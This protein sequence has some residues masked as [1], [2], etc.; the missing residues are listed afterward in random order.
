M[1]SRITWDGGIALKQLEFSQDGALLYGLEFTGIIIATWR[2][3]DGKRIGSEFPITGPYE[4]FRVSPD[5][6]RLAS[7]GKE[8]NVCHQAIGGSSPAAVLLGHEDRIHALAY[9]PDG[10]WIASGGNDHTCRVWNALPLPPVPLDSTGFPAWPE[11][12]PESI[13]TSGRK[14]SVWIRSEAGYW[15]GDTLA[16]GKI[17]F[18]PHSPESPVREFNAPPETYF[19]LD[20]SADGK[21]LASFS[22]PRNLR[23]M[24]VASGKWSS[25]RRITTGTAGPIAFSADSEWIATGADDN[26][27]TIHQRESGAVIAVLR[28]HQGMLLDI[29]CSPDGRTLA[30]SAEDKTLRLWH[31]AT[32]RDLGVLHQGEVIPHLVFSKNGEVLRGITASG[33]HR[34]FG[35]EI[36]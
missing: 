2:V 33:A 17:H 30:S 7:N 32:W 11:T 9:S 16:G 23:V 24:D 19:R 1:K 25:N 31:I 27:I 13:T 26:C 8:Q 28:G 4:R 34:D 21:Y 35:G 3:S 14:V 29:A 36:R 10:R 6:K 5:D 20:S 22:W 15:T 18:H 12:L